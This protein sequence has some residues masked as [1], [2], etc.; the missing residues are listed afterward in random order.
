MIIDASALLAILLEEPEAD[1]FLDVL[2][3]DESRAISP[4]NLV[5]AGIKADDPRNPAKGPALD[6]LIATLSIVVAPMTA[7]QARIARHA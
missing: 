5:E 7:E 1:Q 3:T 2:H 6:A 4:V